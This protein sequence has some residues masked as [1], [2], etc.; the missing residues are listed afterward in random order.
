MGIH[1][2]LTEGKPLTDLSGT[3]LVDENGSFITKS[4]FNYW[5]V[6]SATTRNRIKAEIKAQYNKLVDHGIHPTHIDSHQHV[7]TLPWLPIFSLIWH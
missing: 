3:S 5:L 2:N 6:F 7:H 1:I 4:I